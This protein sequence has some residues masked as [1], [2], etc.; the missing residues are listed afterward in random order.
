MYF[1]KG[2]NMKIEK[3]KTICIAFYSLDKYFKGHQNVCLYIDD[4]VSK[5]SESIL[6][7]DFYFTPVK[8]L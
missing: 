4:A 6:Y 2:N 7:N 1:K 8:D 5:Q 3:K